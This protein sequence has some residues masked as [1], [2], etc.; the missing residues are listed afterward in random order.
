VGVGRERESER[1]T[2]DGVG[3]VDSG[4]ILGRLANKALGVG[5]GHPRRRR[6]VA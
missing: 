2:E 3:G 1:R 4:L 6:T 5:E